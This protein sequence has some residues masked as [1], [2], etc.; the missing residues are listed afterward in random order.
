MT[1]DREA[2]LTRMQILNNS[3]EIEKLRVVITSFRI[4][5]QLEGHQQLIQQ[6]VTHLLSENWQLIGQHQKDIAHGGSPLLMV[7]H[8]DLI[9]TQKRQMDLLASAG[10]TVPPEPG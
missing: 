9:D 5:G 10:F 1:P 2:F 8:L 6:K 7:R 3:D 4:A